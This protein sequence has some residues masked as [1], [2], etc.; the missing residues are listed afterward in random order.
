MTQISQMLRERTEELRNADPSEFAVQQLVKEAGMS[1]EDA[2]YEVAQH[3]MEKEA[4]NHL[5]AMSGVDIE[6]A[7]AL[8]KAAGVNVRELAAFD[9]STPEV[10]TATIDL[11]EK[12][13]QYIESL[14]SELAAKNEEL[15]K[16]AHEVVESKIEE[17]KLPE[18]FE[19]LATAGA[20]TFEDLEALRAVQPELLHKV[21]SVVDE[22]WEMGRGAGI[23]RPKTDPL[24]EFML[25]G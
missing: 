19:K 1:V 18:A 12:A 25:G 6:Q 17:V 14:E 20:F 15:E 2:R 3:L 10:D 22:P 8:V 24:L 4:A 5:V 23:A 11:L 13:A 16:L 9:A 21:A 7:V